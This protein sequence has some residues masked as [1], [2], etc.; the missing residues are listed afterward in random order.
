M[1][2]YTDAAATA[3]QVDADGWFYT[4]DVGSVD[5]DGWVTMTGR[6]KDIVNRG[7]EKFSCQDIEQV[8]ATHPA[9]AAA[10]VLGVPDD[11]LG[12][13]VAAFVTLRPGGRWPGRQALVDHLEGARL[14]RPK[15]PVEWRVLD[16]IPVTLSGKVQKHQLLAAWTDRLE[17][18]GNPR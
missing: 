7:G 8:I 4:G 14:A 10:A 1:L 11:R 16:A 17:T 9:I 6:I 5:G 15:H 3:A 18:Q 2:G 13:K 12:E